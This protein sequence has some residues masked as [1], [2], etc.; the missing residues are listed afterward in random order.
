MTFRF[1]TECEMDLSGASYEDIYLQFKHPRLWKLSFYLSNEISTGLLFKNDF[2][3]GLNPENHK[4][5]TVA[6]D[7]A[8]TH[9]GY[10]FWDLIADRRR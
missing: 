3:I 10:R 9:T 2:A 4:P 1:V 8:A 5:L 6:H 7:D